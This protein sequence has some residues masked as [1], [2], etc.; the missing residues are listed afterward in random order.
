MS[1]WDFHRFH[2]QSMT[3]VRS[4]G[5]KSRFSVPYLSLMVADPSQRLKVV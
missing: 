5:S 2:K 1:V 4:Y 3:V